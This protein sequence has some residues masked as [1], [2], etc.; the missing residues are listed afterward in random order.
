MFGRYAHFTDPVH[1]NSYPTITPKR[2]ELSQAGR[3]V[4]ITGGGS[5]IGFGIARGFVRASAAKVIIL[6][7]RADV[8]A[9]AAETLTKEGEKTEVI[10]IPCDI[11][12]KAAVD[13][14][15]QRLK[16]E[17]TVVDVLA[18]NAVGFPPVKPLLECGVEEI[19][20]VYDVNVR[21]QLQMTDLFYK[22]EGQ[23]TSETKYLIYVSSVSVH[24]HNVGKEQLG[25]AL[26]KNSFQLA[27]QLITMNT[28]PEKMQVIS[29]HPGAIFTES[30][31][32]KGW[33]ENTIPWDHEKLI[34]LILRCCGKDSITD[35]HSRFTRTLRRLGC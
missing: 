17:G 32:D 30:A 19:W 8:I 20:K 5:G 25:Y 34:S 3:T 13:T 2:P 14:L 21:A 9:K 22:Q 23:E 33:T 26:T 31:R 18:L 6:G 7:R 28:P 15:W 35:L 1:N 27:L 29:Y 16:E 4:L 11:A 10:G 24:D 12:D